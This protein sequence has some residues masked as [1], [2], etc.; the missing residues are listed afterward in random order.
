MPS[1]TVAR[2]SSSTGLSRDRVS[3]SD[4]ESAREAR[5]RAESRFSA[6]AARATCHGRRPR[7]GRHETRITRISLLPP[8]RGAV[9]V[10][11]S[12]STGTRTESESVRLN[13]ESVARRRIRVRG[14]GRAAERRESSPS[15]WH[16]AAAGGSER[17]NAL[18]LPSSLPLP[19]SFSLHLSRPLP[20]PLPL[21][22][23]RIINPVPSRP[24]AGEAAAAAEY[25]SLRGA[26]G[27]SG[28]RPGRAG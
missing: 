13:A 26:E 17:G 1:L 23:I 10:A 14:R 8:S 5:S 19:L 22:N 6:A 3:L 28:R 11:R 12:G 9:T 16:R 24:W 20:L 7:A 27:R 2:G 15:K 4:S 25:P 21:A 18:S